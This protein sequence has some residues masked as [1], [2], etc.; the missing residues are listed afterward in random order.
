MEPVLL[1]LEI[2]NDLFEAWW[3]E[4]YTSPNA[5][6]VDTRMDAL[7]I[8]VV[9]VKPPHQSN[10]DYFKYWKPS[11]EIEDAPCTMKHT[12]F[13]AS[14]VAGLGVNQVF[15]LVGHRA[16]Y[17]YIWCDLMMFNI[18]KEGLTIKG[19]EDDSEDFTIPSDPDDGSW[20]GR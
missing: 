15:N 14:I 17:G 11:I 12:I 5:F 18:K 6:F 7:A 3:T 13:T 19:L 10:V 1:K 8:E 4:H 9:T 20:V 2:R 16:Y